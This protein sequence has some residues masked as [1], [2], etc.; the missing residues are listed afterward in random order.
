MV[1][2]IPPFVSAATAEWGRP[3][4]E[5]M[6]STKSTSAMERLQKEYEAAHG[7]APKAT[8]AQVA[9]HVEHVARVAGRLAA[10]RSPSTAVIDRLDGRP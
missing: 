9:D 1:T 6:Q 10:R 4:E 3:L 2:F 8:L 5:L 7:P